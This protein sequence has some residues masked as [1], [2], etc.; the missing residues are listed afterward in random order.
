MSFW[1]TSF[2]HKICSRRRLKFLNGSQLE[3]LG[4]TGG[5]AVEPPRML[6]VGPMLITGDYLTHQCLGPLTCQVPS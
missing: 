1:K 4:A 5:P 6:V 3:S 2:F